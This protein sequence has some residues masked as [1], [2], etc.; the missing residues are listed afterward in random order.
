VVYLVLVVGATFWPFNFFQENL[1]RPA[2]GSGLTFTDPATAY[3]E[4]PA[5]G[6]E[7]LKEFTIHLDL[8]TEIPGQSAW[9]LGY[10]ADF[11]R[12]NLLVGLYLNNLI[13][14]LHRGDH[15]MRASV[16]EGLRAGERSSLVIVGTRHSLSVFVNG[17][18]RREVSRERDDDTEWAASYPLVLG[19]RSDGKYAWT[20][21]LYRVEMFNR[22]TS[23][24]LIAGDSL[25][26]AGEPLLRYDFGDLAGGFV[27]NKG[28]G[29]IGPLVVPSAFVPFRR[30][31]F[32]DLEEPG[33][34]Y[35]WGD[36][37]LNVLV[38]LPI[39]F[40]LGAILSGRLPGGII[41]PLVIMATFGLSLTIE[42]LQ[43]YLP[44]RW[45]TL[46]DVASNT[47]GGLIGAILYLAMSTRAFFLQWSG[48]RG[49]NR[50]TNG[51]E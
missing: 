27:P 16:E 22:A 6:L 24:D 11:E 50:A 35:L 4:G 38:F 1:V 25:F 28:T 32:M 9:I 8:E 5:A 20:G 37:F 39:G 51:T 36:I 26:T 13:V 31:V 49:D 21:T 30:A 45:S 34:R 29:R 46:T 10:G 19:T 17:T 2:A 44:R 3:T 15:R 14:E 18:L 23:P 12:L 47:G 7:D 42:M 41:I 33:S 43:V 48:R 40:M